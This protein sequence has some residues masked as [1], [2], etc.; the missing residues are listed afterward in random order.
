VEFLVVYFDE[1]RGVVVNSAP[2][3][4]MT[5]QI[6]MLQ[7]GSYII[8]LAPPLNYRPLSIPIELIN[9]TVLQ[10]REIYFTMNPPSP[11]RGTS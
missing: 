7:A 4:W 8:E 1:D 11:L 3:A 9:T 5:N 10:P 6:L 2:G